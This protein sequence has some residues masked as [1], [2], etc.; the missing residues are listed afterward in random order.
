MAIRIEA[1]L[2]IERGGEVRVWLT[3]QSEHLQHLQHWREVMARG[4]ERGGCEFL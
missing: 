3:Q 1:W 2:G 4:R